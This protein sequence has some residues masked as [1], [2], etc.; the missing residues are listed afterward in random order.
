VAAGTAG[1]YRAGVYRAGDLKGSRVERENILW[2]VGWHV[3]YPIRCSRLDAMMAAQ[4]LAFGRCNPNR[5]PSVLTRLLNPPRSLREPAAGRDPRA[6]Q[7]LIAIP[8]SRRRQSR[9]YG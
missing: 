2:G 9:R 6:D 5:Q 4:G 1:V 3:A 7:P 8:L